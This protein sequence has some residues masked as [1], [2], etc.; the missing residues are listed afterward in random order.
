MA[1]KSKEK[2][3]KD[4]EAD[5]INQLKELG[6]YKEQFKDMVSIYSGLIH[7]Y[8]SFEREFIAS[9]Y[10]IEEE[11]TNKAGATNMRKVPLYGAME[12][13]RKDIA[14]YSDRLGLN[15]KSMESITAEKNE[16]SRLEKVLSKL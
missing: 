8:E 1:R 13:L 15:P 9:G 2:T 3:K 5:V 6:T 12:S 4:I 10:K 14:T 16:A 11:Y 7:Q